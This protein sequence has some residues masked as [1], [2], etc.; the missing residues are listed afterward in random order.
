M[1]RRLG[2]SAPRIANRDP[3]DIA[4]DQLAQSAAP[5]RK[6]PIPAKQRSISNNQNLAIA[7]ASRH[8]GS[9]TFPLLTQTSNRREAPHLLLDRHTGSPKPIAPGACVGFGIRIFFVFFIYPRPP[10]NTSRRRVNRLR[11]RTRDR[12]LSSD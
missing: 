10:G 4:R 8:H 3:L 6:Q 2:K 1:T 7:V 5:L 9:R 11:P 12:P